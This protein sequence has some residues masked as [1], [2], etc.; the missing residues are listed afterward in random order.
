MATVNVVVAVLHLQGNS[1]ADLLGVVAE[2][3]PWSIEED[4]E[5]PRLL[6]D[7]LLLQKNWLKLPSMT[8]TGSQGSDYAVLLGAVLGHRTVLSV[9]AVQTWCVFCCLWARLFYS[10]VPGAAQTL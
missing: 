2:D 1:Q 10:P 8:L 9:L 6:L 5:D 7:D 4:E 3:G